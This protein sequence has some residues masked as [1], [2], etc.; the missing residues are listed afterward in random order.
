MIVYQN[1]DFVSGLLQEIYQIGLLESAEVDAQA[2]HGETANSSAS[3]TGKGRGGYGVPFVGRIDLEAGGEYIRQQASNDENVVADRKKFVYS[4]AFY[5]DRVRAALRAQR[6]VQTLSKKSDAQSAAVGS[7]VEF[8]ATFRANEVNAVLDILTPDLTAAITKYLRR[9][10]GTNQVRTVAANLEATGDF[11]TPEKASAIRAIHEA[12]AV[13]Q[14]ELASAITT[15]VR[16]DFRGDRTK[17]FYATVGSDD[18][19]FTAVTVCEA[20]HFVTSDSDR[21]LDGRFTVLAKV[22]SAA[23][24]DVP[25]LAK[26]KLLNRFKVDA[27][28]DAIRPIV[29][30]RDAGEFFDLDFAAKI[31]GTSIT[32][33]PV[34]IYI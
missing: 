2:T 7:F 3:G 8:H 13:N 25:I 12:E 4:Q 20:E 9:A 23:R 18:A 28:E 24:E 5:M 30:D 33:M 31:D 27:V 19:A 14:A 1:P 26:N 22:I 6:F 34:A 32:V 11:I 21:L 17:E 10:A 29:E 15:A 16:A